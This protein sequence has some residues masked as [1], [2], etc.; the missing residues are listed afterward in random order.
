MLY[1]L[2]GILAGNALPMQTS[3]NAALRRQLKN[4]LLASLVSFVCTIATFCAALMITEGKLNFPLGVLLGQPFWVWLPGF[5]GIFFLIGNILLFPKLGGVRTIICTATGQVLMALLVDA[6]GLFSVSFRSAGLARI[7]GAALALAGVAVVA[8]S[9][10]GGEKRALNTGNLAWCALGVLIGMINVTQT[11]IN[12]R[13]AALF[14]NAVKA[15]A[16]SSMESLPWVLALM[17]IMHRRIPISF[18]EARGSKPWMWLGGVF[19][20]A[21]LFF[22]AFLTG[23]LGAGLAVVTILIGSTL[24]GILIDHFGLFGADRQRMTLRKALGVLL[25]LCGTVLIRLA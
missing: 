13:V 7:A 16:I 20:A 19:G 2:L 25:M 24:G 4:P 18:S 8:L 22:N 23:K 9:K 12:A 1:V 11:T 5:L 10:G 21:L 17:L 3:V 14:G 15:T 6:L